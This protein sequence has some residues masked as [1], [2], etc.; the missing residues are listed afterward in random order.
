MVGLCG[1]GKERVSMGLRGEGRSGGGG[2]T[3]IW[4]LGESVFKERTGG[5]SG[6]AWGEGCR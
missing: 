5:V 3:N 2:S 1:K 6:K 4:S